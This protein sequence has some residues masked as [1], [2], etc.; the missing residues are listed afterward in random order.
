MLAADPQVV[1][2]SPRILL[3]RAADLSQLF[4]FLQDATPL[5]WDFWI[6]L[7]RGD[8]NR[9]ETWMKQLG[10]LLQHVLKRHIFIKECIKSFSQ[11]V[12]I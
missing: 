8:E 6:L 3:R 10:H 11:H 12:Y 1:P 4:E 2:R 7:G 9:I 5:S